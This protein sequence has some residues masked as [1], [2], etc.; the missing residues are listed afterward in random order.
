MYVCQNR[1]FPDIQKWWRERHQGDRGL[2]LNGQQ[3]GWG[4]S[5]P[6]ALA[7]E[8]NQERHGGQTDRS[9]S[10][11]DGSTRPYTPAWRGD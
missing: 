9:G 11:G 6:E 2:A 3:L 7:A 10:G 8:A 1:S 5:Q 4:C